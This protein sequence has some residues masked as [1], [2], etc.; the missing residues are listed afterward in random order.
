MYHG[1]VTTAASRP[2]HPTWVGWR[3]TSAG[4]YV[5]IPAGGRHG[6]PSSSAR[7]H[8]VKPAVSSTGPA[9][10]HG[11][12]PHESAA[13]S[14]LFEHH[15]ET[16]IF[17]SFIIEVGVIGLCTTLYGGLR[18]GREGRPGLLK[19]QNKIFLMQ[20]KTRLTS[21]MSSSIVL[22]HSTT[23]SILPPTSTTRSVDWGQHSWNNLMLVFVFWRSIQQRYG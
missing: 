12:P 21:A 10:A 7:R 15:S 8:S 1:H 11:E 14:S 9:P 3:R 16:A 13:A 4:T 5:I 18:G 17:V 2:R 22:I 6:P 23:L 20:N 19:S